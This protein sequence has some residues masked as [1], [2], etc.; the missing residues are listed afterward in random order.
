MATFALM[1]AHFPHTRRNSSAA[2]DSHSLL[3]RAGYIR[4]AGAA[5]VFALLPLGWRVH[6]RLC[7]LIF[8]S[9]DEAGVHN[10]HLPVLQPRTL[11]EQTGRW[12]AYVETKSM[13]TT[14]EEHSRLT[15][16]LAPTS[17]EVMTY[18]A[19]MEIHSWRDLPLKCHQIGPKFRD[20]LRP[21]MGLVRSREFFMSDAYSFDRD[22]RGM[23]ESFHLMESMYGTLFERCGLR[24]VTSVTAENG[25]IGGKES[26]AFLALT[27]AGE[28]RAFVCDHCDYRASAALA[29]PGTVD[30]DAPPA[31]HTFMASTEDAT[32]RVVALARAGVEIDT[33][34]L[35]RSVGAEHIEATT[36]RIEG[37]TD[38]STRVVYDRSVAGVK[39]HSD[40]PE[41][42]SVADIALVTDGAPCAACSSGVLHD[43]RGI[44]IGHIFMLD[45]AYA[46]KMNARYTDKDGIECSIWMGCYGIGTTRLMQALVE[47]NH[48]EHGII[49]PHRVAPYDVY[50]VPI[51]LDEPAHV[52]SARHACTTLTES[53]WTVL[54]D[55]RALRAGHKFMDADLLG[56]PWRIT[57]GRRA[58]DGIVELSDRRTQSTS[59][60]G[61]EHLPRVL[62]E[63]SLRRPRQLFV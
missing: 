37:R 27:E 6:Q 62:A 11:W 57:A 56:I 29:R 26:V 49:W 46:D 20:E 5:G 2:S 8:A 60:V 55:D 25:W 41:G 14:T 24:A 59:T 30:I 12:S 31:T 61:I 47:Q 3:E 10:L 23:R 22:E 18:L 42:E 16:G 39:R 58:T 4:Q 33:E 44:E 53:G 21:R 50:V 34:R 52:N 19:A 63:K 1:S 51:N 9:M 43:R 32:F 7:S 13:F 38:I 36:T 40:V 35:A 54:L 48:D 15:F 28:D 45:T 17:E